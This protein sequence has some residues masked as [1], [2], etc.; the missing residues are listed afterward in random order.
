[1]RTTTEV[2]ELRTTTEVAE[3][4]HIHNTIQGY[5]FPTGRGNF[6]QN[7]ADANVKRYILQTGPCKFKGPFPLTGNRRFSTYYFTSITKAGFKLPRSW[8]CYS[9]KLDCAYCELC[10]LFAVVKAPRTTMPG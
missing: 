7:I 1:M 10:W 3:I 4:L 9:P 5:D 2:A 6:P 8:L